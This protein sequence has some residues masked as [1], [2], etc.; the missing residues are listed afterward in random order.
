MEQTVWK[1]PAFVEYLVFQ[2]QPDLLEQYLDIDHELFGQGLAQFPGFLGSQVLLSATRPGEVH[3][4]IFW[5]SKEC[6]EAV[7]QAFIQETDRE[8][9]RRLGEGNLTL[10]RCAHQENE[11]YLAREFR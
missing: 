8:L 5:E 1:R 9:N 7:P 11:L 10:L 6:L 3:S 2:V 4:L